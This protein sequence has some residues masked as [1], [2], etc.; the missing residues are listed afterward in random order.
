MIRSARTPIPH[1][2]AAILAAFAF[3]FVVAP[4]AHATRP[5]G[6]GFLD[7]VHT[8]DPGERD[9]W[10]DRT[11]AVGA[12]IIR[13]DIGWPAPPTATRP[14]GFD[15]RD[16]ADPHYDFSSADA[17]IVAADARGLRILA[18]FVYAPPWAE[19]SGRPKAAVKG[20]WKPSP[21]ALEDYGAAL[22]RR[23]SGTFADPARPGQML[24]RVAAFQVWNE[25]NLATYLTPQWSGRRPAS[26]A[27]YRRMLNG[28][29]RGVRSV[30]ST[31]LV[32][33]AGTAPFG[34]LRPGGRRVPPARFWRELLCLRQTRAGLRTS[35]CASPARF[36]VLAHH[37]YSVGT[38]RRKAINDDDVS[39]P[40]IGKLTRLLR[41]AERSARALPRRMHPVWVTE[42]SYDSRPPDPNGVPEAKHARW[43]QET[44]YLLWRQG[45]SEI[46]WFQV[47]DQLPEPSY[48]AS[49]QSGVFLRDGRAKLAATAFRL[50]LV[51]ER[52][53][54]DSLRVW[55][56]SPLAGTVVI[57]RR[58]GQRWQALRRVQVRRGGTFL[59]RVRRSTRQDQLRARV[60]ERDEPRLARELTRSAPGVKL[61]AN[62]SQTDRRAFVAPTVLAAES[63]KGAP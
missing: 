18:S 7:A 54:K 34:D 45:V 51:A 35:T 37:T 6:L 12:D 38:P 57:E 24:P 44:L 3:T 52:A 19:G 27:L 29:Y 11:V 4:I 22:A 30:D 5:L 50:P 13:L 47:R 25:P 43:L 9:P 55:G 36:D 21:A 39:I 14:A 63:D 42:V 15:A 23:Y 16:P 32:V 31:A 53:G 61:G 40:D 8:A 1:T 59:V 20:S 62:P 28:F 10:L 58:A 56:R 48:E 33:T 26:P 2:I 17:D 41:A 60:G 46:I 49:N